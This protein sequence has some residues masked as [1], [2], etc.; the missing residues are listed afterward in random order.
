MALDDLIRLAIG[1]AAMLGAAAA[2]GKAGMWLLRVLQKLA[3]LTDDLAGE[4]PR[5]GMPDGRKG[6]LDRLAAI[7]DA[8][9][10]VPGL[11]AR[12]ARVETHL[13]LDPHDAATGTAA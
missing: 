4:P 3:R 12:L 10:P 11:E 1:V 9:A 13:H 5:P 2:A 6:V 7:E 8:L